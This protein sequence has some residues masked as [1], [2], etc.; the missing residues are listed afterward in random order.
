MELQADVEFKHPIICF[1]HPGNYLLDKNGRRA[2]VPPPS[3]PPLAT[4]PFL[5]LLSPFMDIFILVRGPLT[6]EGWYPR[7]HKP[8]EYATTDE[9]RRAAAIKLVIC[10]II[11]FL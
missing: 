10:V 5:P 11:F 1:T 3:A 7:D 8:G 6:F 9:Q 4:T 2:V